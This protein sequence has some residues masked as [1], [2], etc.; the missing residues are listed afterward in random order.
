MKKPQSGDS[1]VIQWLGLHTSTAGGAGSTPGPGTKILQVAQSGQKKP[2]SSAR[3]PQSL[4][5]PALQSH[6]SLTSARPTH[7]PGL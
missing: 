6:F 7:A 3:F 5:P 1:I 4:S 2:Q